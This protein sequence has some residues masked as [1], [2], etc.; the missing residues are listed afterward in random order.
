MFLFGKEK[1]IDLGKNHPAMVTYHQENYDG[2]PT[3]TALVRRGYVVISI[4]AF[5]FGERRLMS[6]PISSTAGTALATHSTTCGTSTTMCRGKEDD[7]R[8]GADLRGPD[9]A[10]HRLLGRHPHRR[11][12][13]AAGPK[14]TPTASAAWASRWAATAR[15]SWRRSTSASRPACVV[16]FMSTVRPMIKAHIDTHSFVHFLP[17]LHRYLDLPDVAA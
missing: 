1:V 5:M 2:R 10:R 13:R 16:G 3:A 15:C 6:T 17:G 9:L 8:Q 11:L 14:S 7:A 4:D 12:P